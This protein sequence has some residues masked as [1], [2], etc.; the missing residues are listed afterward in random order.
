MMI[1]MLLLFILICSL[2]Q[3]N[4]ITIKGYYIIMRIMILFTISSY[5]Y[6]SRLIN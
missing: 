3:F 6:H 5:Y 2:L 4:I 1:I